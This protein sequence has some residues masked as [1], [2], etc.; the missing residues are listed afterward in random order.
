MRL[1]DRLNKHE[2][3]EILGKCWITHDGMWFYHAVST[4][5][6]DKANQLNKSAIETMAPIEIKRMKK[7]MDITKEKFT[8]FE[9]LKDFIVNVA[10]L[11]IPDFMN[12]EI[13]FS[14][15]DT[16]QWAFNERKCFAYNGVS[17]LGVVDGYECG[18]LHRIQCWLRFLG[19]PYKME[20]EVVRCIMPS[21][22]ECSG[23]FRLC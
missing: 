6:I 8:S 16:I 3:K 11:L 15:P 12:V 10:D 1:I 5:G 18:P 9:E 17:M 20:P 21:K 13:S 22:G 2:L 23:R 4:L 19:V 14:E 7:A